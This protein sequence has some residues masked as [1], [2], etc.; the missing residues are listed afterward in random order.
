MVSEKSSAKGI[1][2]QNRQNIQNRYN[3]KMVVES[4]RETPVRAEVDVLVVGGGLA[5]VSAAVAAARAGARTML[6]ERNSFPGGVATAGMCCSVFNCF[7]TLER[8]L[9]VK[10]NPLE[11]VNELSEA[12][13]PGL[14]WHKH[15]GHIIYDIEK[16]KLVLIELLEK[17]GV[18]YLFETLTV[19]TVKEDNTIKGVIIE[20]KSG[21]EAVHAKVV[22]DAS[23]DSDVACYSGAPLKQLELESRKFSSYVFRVGNVDV[24]KFVQYFK[25]N[26]DQYPENMDIEWTL[27]EAVKQYE[28]TGTFLFPH[29]GGIQMDIIKKGIEKGKFKTGIGMHHTLNALQMHAIRSLGVVHMITGHVE[30]NDLD[31]AKISRS[32]SDG[33]RMAFHITDFFKNHIP[34]FEKSNVVGTADDL[35]I[36]ASR[37]IDGDFVFNREMKINPSRFDDAIGRGVIEDHPVKH[38]GKGAW[39]VQAFGNDY[40]EIPYRCLLPRK[41]EGLIMGSGRSISAEDPYLLRVMVTTMVVGQSAGVAAA[42]SAKDDVFPRNVEILKVQDELRRQGVEI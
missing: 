7:Y 28:E 39:G 8:E 23:G 14:D 20:S 10:G 12:Y 19:G 15:K 26:P 5:G 35:G 13:G 22:V 24:D 16:G 37:W 9:V 36:R 4:E 25:D 18:E 31:V 21:R 17:A 41:I 29:G 2:I 3:A 1:N 32:M 11:F 33:K 40:Y 42:V 27:K 30:V 38:K 34:G 6:V